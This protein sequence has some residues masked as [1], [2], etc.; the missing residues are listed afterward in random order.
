MFLFGV[1][2]PQGVLFWDVPS[3]QLFPA[4][5]SFTATLQYITAHCLI[6][7]M[8]CFVLPTFSLPSAQLFT[9]LSNYYL[10][11][12]L[13]HLSIVSLPY[14]LP[15]SLSNHPCLTIS[16]L[17]PTISLKICLTPHCP[18]VSLL[19]VPLSH[20]PLSKCPTVSLT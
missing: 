19:T 20:C 7:P 11:T 4:L 6:D 17:L 1:K 9:P 15:T 5:M 2:H 16:T 12:F 10:L 18:T 14:C 8:S 3:G 13:A